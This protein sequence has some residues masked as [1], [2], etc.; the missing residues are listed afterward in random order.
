MRMITSLTGTPAKPHLYL[1]G[2]GE[3][4]HQCDHSPVA[5]SHDADTIGIY[6][7]EILYHVIAADVDILVFQSSII[8]IIVSSLAIPPCY[9]RYSAETT[10]Y[11]WAI[12]SRTIWA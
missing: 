6:D 12:S 2:V 10:M 4:V 1:P 11:S 7:I 3:E 5:P 8:D 9:P